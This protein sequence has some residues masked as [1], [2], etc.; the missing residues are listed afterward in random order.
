MDHSFQISS[1]DDENVWPAALLRLM[2]LIDLCEDPLPRQAE[3]LRHR[4]PPLAAGELRPA[5][6][7]LALTM[8][9]STANTMAMAMGCDLT[10][11]L[12]FCD[13]DCTEPELRGARAVQHRLDRRWGGAPIMG[14]KALAPLALAWPGPTLG[15][16]ICL[17]GRVEWNGVAQSAYGYMALR[18]GDVFGM[19]AGAAVL[20]RRSPVIS[21]LD[22]MLAAGFTYGEILAACSG[23]TPTLATAA[24]VFQFRR[25]DHAAVLN[26]RTVRLTPAET[27]AMELLLQQPGTALSRQ[28]M[29]QGLG[30]SNPRALDHIILSLRNKLGDGLIATVYGTGYAFEVQPPS[31][32]A[33]AAQ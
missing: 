21:I 5:I 23:R 14:V 30:L 7:P 9:C 26:G 22:T 15:H 25:E 28:E 3:A 33:A 11:L 17:H 29:I 19:E 12:R 4:D 1:A 10:T 27:R 18:R 6:L 24:G 16:I 20:V 31:A 13:P 32:A 2:Q 8:L